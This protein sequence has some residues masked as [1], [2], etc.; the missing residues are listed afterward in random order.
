M[1]RNGV[2]HPGWDVPRFQAGV[3]FPHLGDPGDDT[4]RPALFGPRDIHLAG[5]AFF[6]LPGTRGFIPWELQRSPDPQF[7]ARE[8]SPKFEFYCRAVKIHILCRQ[9]V[10]MPGESPM[11]PEYESPSFLST[12]CH[13]V[14]IRRGTQGSVPPSLH[15]LSLTKPLATRDGRCLD[16]QA[17]CG[18]G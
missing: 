7:L 9:C 3:N 1:V 2:A 10:S 13:D 5:A 18:C 6:R 8:R 16:V 17:D 14:L 4:C 15:A 11:V 12:Q